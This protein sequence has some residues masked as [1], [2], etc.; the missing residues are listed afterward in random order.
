MEQSGREA[1][2]RSKK[3]SGGWGGRAE[4]AVRKGAGLGLA[5]HKSCKPGGPAPH[6]I[7][8]ND[9]LRLLARL[10]MQAPTEGPGVKCCERL[11]QGRERGGRALLSI[12]TPAFLFFVSA[13]FRIICAALSIIRNACF[14][15]CITILDRSRG[16]LR[17]RW[18][19]ALIANYL[20]LAL[21]ANYLHLPSV[22]LLLSFLA[23]IRCVAPHTRCGRRGSPGGV[24][25]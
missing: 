7:I 19:L 18:A 24:V 12:V 15:I 17:R 11:P 13:G 10:L 25:G 22:C 2:A 16:I 20:H 14:S 1:C 4:P 3:E 8:A 21:I 9:L 23:N 5:I 6:G